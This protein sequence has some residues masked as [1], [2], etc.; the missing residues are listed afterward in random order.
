M[1][2]HIIKSRTKKN[3][4][5]I[6]KYSEYIN[7]FSVLSDGTRQEI[8]ALFAK[9]KEM[10]A[11]DVADNFSLSRPTISHHLNLMKK[12]DIL[13]SRKT[14][15]EIYYSLNKKH[16]IVKLNSLLTNLKKYC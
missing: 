15:K 14:G 8:I 1:F 10:R 16:L 5:P 9:K 12:S 11:N 4:C 6:K 3:T 7:L 2:K 13:I